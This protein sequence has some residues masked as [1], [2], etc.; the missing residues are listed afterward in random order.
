MFKKREFFVF[1][2]TVLICWTPFFMGAWDKTIPIAGRKARYIDDDIRTNNAGIE[3]AFDLQHKFTTGGVLTG[4]HEDD[5]L[6]S[7]HIAAGAVDL[8]HM[9][10][11]SI[12]SDQYVDGSIDAVH[13]AADVIDE[14]K[15][16]DNGIDSEHYNDDSIDPAHLADDFTFDTFPLSPSAAPDADYE[17]ANK[18][19]VDDQITANQ[20][21]AYSGGQ[22]HT[23][24]GGLITKMGRATSITTGTTITFGTAFPTAIIS[25]VTNIINPSGNSSA[26][27][28]STTGFDLYHNGGGTKSVYWIAIGH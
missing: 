4:E 23:F 10:A 1:I 18:K 24:N 7:K 14:T 6:D 28:V 19:Y 11:N 13:L 25:V 27:S 26:T 16:A 15:I 3:A 20:D 8:E 2:L 5:F 21:P 9:S 17:L 22:S 12:D